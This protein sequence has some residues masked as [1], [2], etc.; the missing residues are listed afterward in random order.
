MKQLVL[1][2]FLFPALAHA[3]PV[4][5][6]CAE[7]PTQPLSG[8][9]V[10]PSARLDIVAV[11][12]ESGNFWAVLTQNGSAGE[13]LDVAVYLATPATHTSGLY[14]LFVLDSDGSW[15]VPRGFQPSLY[16]VTCETDR[17]TLS[18]TYGNLIA[19]D[20]LGPKF[21][22]LGFQRDSQPERPALLAAL[23][24]RWNGA[25][26]I[27]EPEPPASLSGAKQLSRKL[28]L[29]L[30]EGSKVLSQHDRFQF[31]IYRD[32]A[33]GFAPP[34]YV[35]HPKKQDM[36]DNHGM[37]PAGILVIQGQG[38][39]LPPRLLVAGNR[40]GFD[41]GMNAVAYSTPPSELPPAQ[42]A[43]PANR[44]PSQPPQKGK[45]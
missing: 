34:F 26:I 40:V 42:Q 24:S 5:P 2:L 20:I 12:A 29:R 19:H 13:G 11:N 32:E 31:W 16:M 36:A 21:D 22:S 14:K 8:S 45:R 25:E 23:P 39:G 33:S 3:M 37:G 6:N 28:Y 38:A 17:V 7:Y 27:Q 41:R 9:W 4:V 1:M 30:S 44:T 10:N 35:L 15:I 18:T 43:A